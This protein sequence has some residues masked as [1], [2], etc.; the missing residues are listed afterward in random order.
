VLPVLSPRRR[1]TLEV[2]RRLSEQAGGAVHY[3]VVGARMRISAWTAYGLLRELERA[4][5][6]SRRYSREPG[7]G[8]GRS[9]ILFLPAAAG[10]DPLRD[11]VERLRGLAEES[12]A[13]LARLGDG[14]LATRLEAASVEVSELLR[15]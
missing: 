4:G 14:Q 12:A 15:R 1:E 9:R 3:T 11:A 13:T 10:A 8:G 6:V 2:L 5:W 7:S